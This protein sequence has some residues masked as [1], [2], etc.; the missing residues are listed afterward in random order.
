MPYQSFKR[1]SAKNHDAHCQ[2]LQGKVERISVLTAL[3]D[4]HTNKSYEEQDHN[5][6]KGLRKR[7]NTERQLLRNMQGD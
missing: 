5:Y 1:F 3:L 7:V 4:M 6:V 2:R